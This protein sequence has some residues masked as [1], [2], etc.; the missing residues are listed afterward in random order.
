MEKFIFVFQLAYI[1]MD[2]VHPGRIEYIAY[3]DPSRI[4]ALCLY[5]NKECIF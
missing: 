1:V 3:C 2:S 5:F 4:Y